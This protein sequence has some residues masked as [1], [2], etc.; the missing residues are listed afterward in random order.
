MS[1]VAAREDGHIPT[2]RPIVI[3]VTD[4][5]TKAERDLRISD[6]FYYFESVTSLSS[7]RTVGRKIGVVQELVLR[8]YLEQSPDLKR[9]MY[10][11]QFLEGAS[12][13]KHKVEFSWYAIE[14]IVHPSV[15]L[16]VPETNG[17]IIKAVDE[18]SACIAVGLDSSRKEIWISEN[19]QIP[20]LSGLRTF[21]DS[22]SKDLR[23]SVLD[24]TLR[25]D[26]IDRSQLLGSLESKRVGAQR[27]SSSEKLGSGIQTIEKAKQASLV[28]IDIDLKNNGTIK[29]LQTEGSKQTL[30]VVALG[31]GVHWTTKDLQVLQTYV[32]FTFLVTDAAIIRYAE[33]VRNL[34]PPGEDFLEF[35]MNY[36]QG[37]TKQDPDEFI[38]TDNDFEIVVPRDETR[39]LREVLSS[40]IRGVNP[41][42]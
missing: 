28:A 22:M 3:C 6:I 35:F 24:G 16:E 41:T 8:R 7:G 31:N 34:T 33:F 11:E 14:A 9:R 25:L 39:S 12:G 37:M 38:S 40:H 1:T 30:S 21:L 15:G 13:A 10:L 18:E 27:F 19:V 36:F 29:P 26:V 32:D 17:L 5:N 2:D 4:E 42:D 23:V 20:K